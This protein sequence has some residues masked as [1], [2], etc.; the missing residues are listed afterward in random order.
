MNVYLMVDIE[1]ISGIYTKEQVSPG[2][3]RFQEGRRFMTAD[4]NACIRGLKEAGVDKIYVHDCHGGGYS[5]L[6][7][8]L[9]LDADYLI[10][11]SVG[12]QRFAGIEECDAVILLGYHAMAGEMGAILEHT[13]NS[14]KVQNMYIN[15]EKVGETAIDAGILGEKGKPVIMV[16]GDDKVC[17]EAEALIPGVVTAEVK[18]GLTC[19]GAMLLPRNKA[20]LLIQEKAKE[21]ILKYNNIK[22]V[23][24]TKPIEFQIEL[25]ERSQLPNTLT[26]PFITYVDG[27]TFKVKGD[28]VEEAFFRARVY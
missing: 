7:E 4:I 17:R 9:S 2:G 21:A 27:R 10:T 13:M 8:E 23:Q 15:G 18:R 24:F 26:H 12:S 25:T 14:T 22:P 20:H 1:G 16:S 28:T 6:Y 11:G 19:F 3:T 5:V